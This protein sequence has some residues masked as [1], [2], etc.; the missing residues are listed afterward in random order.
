MGGDGPR[1]T[2]RN[3]HD[4]D[5]VG[6]TRVWIVACQ[7]PQ[8][9]LSVRCLVSTIRPPDRVEPEFPLSRTK[10]IHHEILK[11]L[12]PLYRIFRLSH[13]DEIS[14]TY[15]PCPWQNEIWRTGLRCNLEG[16]W[17]QERDKGKENKF[18]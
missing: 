7:S 9:P 3:S 4:K 5:T 6:I 1:C 12:C 10:G 17:V 15:N 13:S 8:K 2:K 11:H 18:C 14:R 16:N